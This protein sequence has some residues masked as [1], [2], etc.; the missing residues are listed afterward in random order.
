M[1]NTSKFE[2]KFLEELINIM[3]SSRHTSLTPVP[4]V[5]RTTATTHK[6]EYNATALKLGLAFFLDVDC[7]VS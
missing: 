4:T 2:L 7:S 5:T 3:I 6:L 1:L